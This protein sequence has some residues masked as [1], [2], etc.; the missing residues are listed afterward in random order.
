MYNNKTM[1]NII[2]LNISAWYSI[3]HKEISKL[4]DIIMFIDYV[5]YQNMMGAYQTL[6]YIT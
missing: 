4:I 1:S 5:A 2:Q 3:Q 6:I